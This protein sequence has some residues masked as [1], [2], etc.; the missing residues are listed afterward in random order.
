M[1]TE[2]F[3]NSSSVEHTMPFKMF[4][5]KIRPNRESTVVLIGP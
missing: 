1:V 2:H 3:A 5:K 4:I